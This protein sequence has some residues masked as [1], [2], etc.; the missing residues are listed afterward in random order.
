MM[1]VAYTAQTTA[2]IHAG[3][4]AR[5]N[6]VTLG[7]AALC[8]T[9]LEQELKRKEVVVCAVGRRVGGRGQEPI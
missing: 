5:S 9:R 7:Q 4:A 6:S 3:S 1:C 8:L 2:Q